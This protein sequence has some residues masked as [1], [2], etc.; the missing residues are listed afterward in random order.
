MQMKLLMENWRS[1]LNEIG[2][3]TAEPFDWELAPQI[4]GDL[5]DVK[6]NF[7]S[8]DD[9]LADD[10]SEY[11]VSFQKS[12]VRNLWS[13]SFDADGSTRETSEGHPLRIMSTV[14]SIVKDFIS[15]PDLNGGTLR[16]IF[17]GIDKG[18]YPGDGETART[19]LYLR[20]LEKNLP[21]NFEFHAISDNIIFFGAKDEEDRL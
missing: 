10:G 21:A 20:F 9:P 6:Y 2:D 18:G 7:V 19:K 3:A 16:F 14:L 15:R 8:S 1:Y 17:E 5:G 4:A 11:E 13:L 12:E